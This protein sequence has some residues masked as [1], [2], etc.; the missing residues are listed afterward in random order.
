MRALTPDAVERLVREAAGATALPRGARLA[1]VRAPRLQVPSGWTSVAL[2]V[3]RLPR[4]AGPLRMNATLRFLRAGESLAAAVV[5]LELLLPPEAATPTL[6]RNA[7]VTL[8]LRAGL[9]EVSTAAWA[10]ADADLGDT[11]PVVL[12]PSGRVLPAR[13]VSPDRAEALEGP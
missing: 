9:V 5:P 8:V 6:A 11:L 4:R 1:G 3:P 2:E 13:L 12:R 7:P 10:G